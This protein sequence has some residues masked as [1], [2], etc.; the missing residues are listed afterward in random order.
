MNILYYFIKR[1][2]V[3]TFDYFDTLVRKKK[4]IIHQIYF[5]WLEE[6]FLVMKKQNYLKKIELML[7]RLLRKFANGLEVNIDDIYMNLKEKYMGKM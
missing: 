3:I 1:K 6:K 2:S 5:T 4:L 7:K